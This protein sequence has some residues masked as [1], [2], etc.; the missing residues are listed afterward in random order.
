MSDT[1]ARQA[2]LN[3]M[4]RYPDLTIDGLDGHRRD[5]F[6]ARRDDL[7]SHS[8]I[9]QFEAARAW[10]DNVPRRTTPNQ[11]CDSYRIKHLIEWTLGL[12]IA[13]GACICAALALGI[14]I[15]RCPSGINAYLGISGAVKSA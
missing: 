13:N 4:A 15:R 10:F 11:R 1:D 8:A 12:Y 3:V 14:D 6:D 9:K 2:I 7:L 5:N